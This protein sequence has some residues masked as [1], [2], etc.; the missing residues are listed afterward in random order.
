MASSGDSLLYT[1]TALPVNSELNW[2]AQVLLFHL[3][4]LAY[5]SILKRYILPNYLFRP[6]KMVTVASSQYF[7]PILDSIAYHSV[8]GRASSFPIPISAFQLRAQISFPYPL[9]SVLQLGLLTSVLQSG[10]LISV[11]QHGLLTSVPRP[12]LL[13]FALQLQPLVFAIQLRRLF[14]VPRPGQLVFALQPLFSVL[15]PRLLTFTLQL[16]SFGAI[17]PL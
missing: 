7:Q 11:L 14:S 17:L 13:I 2:V 15:Q 3:A 6:R 5:L 12:G 16:L 1:S 9:F 10:C 4:T 8:I